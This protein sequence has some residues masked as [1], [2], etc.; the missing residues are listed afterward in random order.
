TIVN[1][2][3]E[4]KNVQFPYELPILGVPVEQVEYLFLLCAVFICLVLINQGFKYAIN[5]YKG[6]TG[7]RMLRRLRFE[8]YGRVLRFPLPTFRKV[9][10]GEVI[11]MI[12]AEV[13]PLGGFVGDAFALPAFQGGTL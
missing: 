6:R 9:S 8:L 2:A 13:E 4:G 5:V 7:E 3:I 11:P 1:Q 12:V 10:Q